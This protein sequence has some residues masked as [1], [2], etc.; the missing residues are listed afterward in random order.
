MTDSLVSMTHSL[1]SSVVCGQI[2]LPVY[3][4]LC[5]ESASLLELLHADHKANAS[6]N[7]PVDRNAV[8][9]DLVG[10]PVVLE[11]AGL[12]AP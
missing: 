5:S 2:C 9:Q 11:A 8:H 7:T 6:N 12:N 1:L 10:N 3:R 4:Q